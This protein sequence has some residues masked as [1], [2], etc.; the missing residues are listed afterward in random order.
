MGRGNRRKK[1]KEMEVRRVMRSTKG[2]IEKIG[3]IR[4]SEREKGRK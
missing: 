1:K 4:S 3:R 2:G